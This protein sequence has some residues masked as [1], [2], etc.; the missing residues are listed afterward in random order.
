LS[1]YGFKTY[2]SIASRRDS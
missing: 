1:L 2:G